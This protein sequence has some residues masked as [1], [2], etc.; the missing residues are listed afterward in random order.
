MYQRFVIPEFKGKYAFLSNFHPIQFM[1]QNH[2]FSTAEHAFQWCKTDDLSEKE[3]IQFA[4]TPGA[5]KA[6]GRNCTLIPNWDS[7]K[8]SVM[9]SIKVA[10]IRQHKEFHRR[11][12]LLNDHYLVEGNHH[13]DNYW[14]VCLCTGCQDKDKQ[15]QLGRIYMDIIKTL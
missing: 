1:F 5:A 14:G 15:N 2:L 3:A 6:L 8:W 4:A 7:E 13:H 10:Q 11:L 12:A 9:Y